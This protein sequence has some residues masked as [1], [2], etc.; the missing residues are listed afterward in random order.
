MV[1]GIFICSRAGD[2]L[3]SVPSAFAVAG[4]GLQGDRYEMGTGVYSKLENKVRQV[5]IIASEAIIKANEGL[6]DRFLPGETR[7]NIIV[8]GI[9]PE[10][11]NKLVGKEFYIGCVRMR[12]AELC[13]PCDRPSAITKKDDFRKAFQMRGGLLA[14][15][16]FD[17]PISV[18]DTLRWD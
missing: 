18:G 4:K 5:S 6:I 7:R 16:L 11:L 17:G 3:N 12:G 13:H 15:V 9:S 10:E 1:V 2:P 8:G 14:E